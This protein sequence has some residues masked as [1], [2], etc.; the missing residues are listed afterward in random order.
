MLFFYGVRNAAIATAPLPG[1]ACAHCQVA[2][3]LSCTVFSRY[4]H[5]FWIPVFPIGKTSATACQHCKQVL[6]PREMPPAYQS[7]VRAVQQATG[8][9]LTHFALLV[10]LGAVMV[11]GFGI[12]LFRKPGN[13]A[14]PTATSAAAQTVA[15]TRYKFNVTD[16]GQQYALIEVTDVTADSVHYRMTDPLRGRL[17]AA[18][19]TQALHDSVAPANAHQRAS[20]QQWQNSATGQGLFKRID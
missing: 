15:G 20:T 19:A 10:L 11:L 5:F 3:K 4:V 14:T 1:V 12:S 7:P 18:S 17:T 13:P 9:P 16:D 6:T 2:G 8:T